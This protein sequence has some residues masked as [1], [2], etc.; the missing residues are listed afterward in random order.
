MKLTKFLVKNYAIF[1]IL[2]FGA[3]LLSIN[4]NKPF[5]GH[6]DFNSAFFSDI[7][8]NL[9]RYSITDTKLGLVLGSGPL[10]PSHLNYYIDNVPLHPWLLGLSFRFFGQGEFQARMVSVIFSLGILFLIYKITEKLFSR[11]TAVLAS[12]LLVTFP[13]FIYFGSSVF[14]E[15]Q[16]IFFS[17]ASFYFF[18]L[19]LEKK[20]KKDYYLLLASSTLSLLTVWGTYFLP[21]LLVLYYFIFNDKKDI[22]KILVLA[23]VPFIVFGLFLLHLYALE[24]ERF[25]SGLSQAL[26]FRL[27]V[28]GGSYPLS[29][30]SFSQEE[31]HR[32]IAYYSKTTAIIAFGWLFLFVL[33]IR[34][35]RYSKKSFLLFTLLL[36]G[37]AY[38][39]IFQKAAYIHDYFLIY[40]APFIAI[41]SAVCIIKI[42]GIFKIQSIA[43]ITIVIAI[44]GFP[45]LQILETK[46]FTR[47]LLTSN[48]NIPGLELGKLL[49]Q[50]TAFHDKILVLS[51]QFGAFFGVFTNYYGDRLV[52]YNDYSLSDFQK[53]K[54]EEKYDYIVYI[55]GRD[56]KKDVAVYLADK[57]S[58]TKEGIFTIFKTKK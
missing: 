41:S 49:A 25:I 9:T 33:E 48:E 34:K 52:N 29:L 30:K 3:F 55:E 28:P 12:L 18:I 2:I 39:L 40:L 27:N 23:S 15:P 8:R 31:F 14:P 6:H 13:I 38:P 44:F 19:W 53:E 43:K 46:N 10:N 47:A 58:F 1:L 57:Y 37:L 35:K 20:Q 45:F 22:K 32:T 17:L 21:P 54:I 24:G 7:A 26:I 11:T 42:A 4:I 50:N 36:W 5:I 51:G 16:A 56:T